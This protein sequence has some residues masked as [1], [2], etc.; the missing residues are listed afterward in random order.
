MIDINL[1]L[2]TISV[3][4]FSRFNRLN[5]PEILL[6]FL[7]FDAYIVNETVYVVISNMFYLVKNYIVNMYCT[8]CTCLKYVLYIRKEIRL[9]SSS[10][11]RK[12]L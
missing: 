8:F 4:Q 6:K 1:K 3:V 5:I 12:H 7:P 9:I 10:K 2:V 11:A